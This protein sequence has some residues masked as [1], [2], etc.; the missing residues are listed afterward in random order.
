MQRNSR[1]LYVPHDDGHSS[2]SAA[3]TK[4]ICASMFTYGIDSWN[5]SNAHISFDIM[6]KNFVIG[7]GWKQGCHLLTY[8]F[9]LPHEQHVID[10]FNKI[11][12]KDVSYHDI[13]KLLKIITPNDQPDT[14]AQ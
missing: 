7:G 11:P 9:K 12:K 6:F 10:D 4:N 2:L 13:Y 8:N 3:Y 5:C 1:F 14:S